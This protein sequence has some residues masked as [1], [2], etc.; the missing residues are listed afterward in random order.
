MYEFPLLFVNS[1]VE[2]IKDQK[3]RNCYDIYIS[4]GV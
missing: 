1:Q 3:N 2:N 4:P